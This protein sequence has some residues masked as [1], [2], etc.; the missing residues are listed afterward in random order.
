MIHGILVVNKERGFTSHQVVAGLR[1]I[2]R[3]SAMGH[4]GTLDPE[5]TGV[6]VVGLGEATR[7]FQFLDERVKLYR[8]E[9]ILG[10]ATDTQDASGKTLAEETGMRISRVDIDSATRKLT[11]AIEQLPPMYSAVKVNGKKLYDLARQGIE[12]ER[13]SRMI[14]VF[15]WENTFSGEYFNYLDSFWAE[16]TCSKGT[17]IRTLIHDLG[18]MLSCGAH[19]GSLVRLQSG[20]F[21]L[22]ESLTLSEIEHYHCEGRLTEH[23]IGLDEALAHLE[24]LAPEE[25]DLDKLRHG[26]KLSYGKYPLPIPPGSFVRATDRKS[27]LIA[28]LCLK[29]TEDR[30]YWQP[31]KVFNVL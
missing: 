5:A 30:L 22:E 29:T 28:I 25:I 21:G 14:T 12:V 6:L 31:V 7:S 13:R 15:K 10:R 26:G 2:L 3:Q 1:R 23:L 8:A 27:R 18:K 24:R 4:T 11:G 9:V 19:M 16:I 17:Y 20:N